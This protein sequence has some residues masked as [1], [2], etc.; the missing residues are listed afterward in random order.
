MF[1]TVFCAYKV[2]WKQY[3]QQDIVN[4]IKSIYTYTTC[5]PNKNIN[6][7][8]TSNKKFIHLPDATETTQIL[9]YLHSN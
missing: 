9:E 2:L 8:F 3:K 5:N 7:S 1:Y 6:V 4:Y